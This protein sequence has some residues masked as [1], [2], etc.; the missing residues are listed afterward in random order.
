MVTSISTNTLSLQVATTSFLILVINTVLNRKLLWSRKLPFKIED[1]HKRT[2]QKLQPATRVTSSDQISKTEH[3]IYK[4]DRWNVRSLT[5]LMN[6]VWADLASKRS[7][8]KWR[9]RRPFDISLPSN[10]RRKC[11]TDNNFSEIFQVF[12]T[13]NTRLAGL[14]HKHLPFTRSVKWCSWP[15]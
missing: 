7:G 6:F 15:A 2:A 4:G 1:S 9:E 14:N 11:L 8:R 13:D 3:T 5:R 12:Y 10:T